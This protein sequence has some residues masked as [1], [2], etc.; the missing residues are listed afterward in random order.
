MKIT[1]ETTE[2]KWHVVPR[3]KRVVMLYENYDDQNIHQ[4][5][6][7]LKQAL[8]ALGYHPETVKELFGD[9]Y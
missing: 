1:I 4:M 6:E 3:R 9:E 5:G 7:L 8:L 2:H